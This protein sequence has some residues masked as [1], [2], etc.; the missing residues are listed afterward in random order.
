[1]MEGG[2]AD[3]E[4][5]TIETL[6]KSRFD[7]SADELRDLVDLAVQ[8]QQD[9]VEIH[10]FTNTLKQ[11]FSEEERIDIREMIWEVAYADGE[12][13]D[14]E[15]HLIR[16]VGGLIHVSDRDRGEARK[17]VLDRLGLSRD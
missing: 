14:Y 17:R 8:K 15:A 11:N 7:L 1:M 2:L 10:R 4:R 12:L 16:R 13:H 3:N 5:Q 6:L 9:A